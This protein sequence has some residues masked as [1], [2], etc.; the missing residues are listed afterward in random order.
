[1]R[2]SAKTAAGSRLRPLRVISWIG[3]SVTRSANV[4]EPGSAVKRT[5]LV[6]PKLSEPTVRSSSTS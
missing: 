3:P 2:E 5:V 6:E 1:M 4:A